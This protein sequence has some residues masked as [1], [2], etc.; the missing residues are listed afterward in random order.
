[1]YYYPRTIISFQL[2][3]ILKISNSIMLVVHV[4]SAKKQNNLQI[5]LTRYE[6]HLTLNMI[7]Q[8]SPLKYVLRIQNVPQSQ[9]IF[10]RILRSHFLP[11][12][13]QHDHHVVISTKIC[14]V[15]MATIVHI[16]SISMIYSI[17][18]IPC[19]KLITTL[20]CFPDTDHCQGKS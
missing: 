3:N 7:Y 6:E 11:G 18:D 20:W 10:L 9:Q 8:N 12:L 17:L 16:G 5:L 13:V 19:V 2:R 15:L 4:T 14:K 1:M